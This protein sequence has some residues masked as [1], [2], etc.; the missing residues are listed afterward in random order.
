M[1]VLTEGRLIDL[2]LLYYIAKKFI[3]PFTKWKAFSLG[4][5]DNKGKRTLKK[6][7]TVEEKNAYTLLD[8]MIRKIRVFVGD[9]W[10]LKLT[11]SYLLIKEDYEVN[12]NDSTLL[13]EDEES[14]VF[15][16]KVSNV[17]GISIR[18][19]EFPDTYSLFISSYLETTNGKEITSIFGSDEIPKEENSGLLD[20]FSKVFN[21]LTSSGF[22]EININDTDGNEVKVTINHDDEL[23]IESIPTEKLY[24]GKFYTVFASDENKLRF[25]QLWN[26]FKEGL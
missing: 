19:K 5:I 18:Y 16:F 17:E 25:I 10:F 26:K 3:T 1:R 21:K 2:V 7:T 11:L 9:K 4:I 15:N 14:K 6:I 23:K 13:L 12:A 24:M 20:K 22:E 8:R